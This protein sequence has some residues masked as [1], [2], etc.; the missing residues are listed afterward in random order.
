M[1]LHADGKTRGRKAGALLISLAVLLAAMAFVFSLS[2]GSREKHLL[3]LHSYHQ[4][5]KWTDDIARGIEAA[6]REEGKIVQVRHE[7]MDTKRI[8]DEAYFKLLHATYKYKFANSR[9]DAIIATDND[10]LDFLLTYRDDLFPETPVV[11]CG[12]N[13][14][15]PSR[16]GGA[17][18]FTGVNEA[19]DI[20]ATL[21]LALKLHP[22]TRHIVVINDTTTT[23]RIMN[24]EIM[25]LVPLYRGRV[26]FASLE[27][28]EM[29]QI[30][31]AVQNL[32][33][34]SIVLFTIFS[35][36]KRGRVFEYDESISLVAG[37]C[38]VPIY[39]VWDFNLGY[40][41][42]GGMLT[43]GFYQ[44]ETAGRMA[45]RILHGEKVENIPVVMESPN[46]YMFDYTQLKKFGLEVSAFPAG[47]IIINK[48]LPLYPAP[49]VF[50]GTIAVFAALVV[51]I[52]ILMRNMGMRRRAEEELRNTV[53][54]YRIIADNTYGWEFWLGPDGKFIY[55]SPSCECITGHSAK[56]FLDDP[57]LLRRIVH[58]DDQPQFDQHWKEILQGMRLGEDQWRILLSNGAVR[59]IDH[60]CMPVF[61]D[62]GQFLGVRGSNSDITERK[63]AEEALLE[64]EER[65]RTLFEGANDAIVIVR[66]GSFV[67][68]NRKTLEL[69]RCSAEEFLGRTP[70]EVSPLLQPDRRES[71]EK[72]REKMASALA[73]VPQFF[74][75]QHLRCDGTLF[76][77]EVSLNRTEYQGKEELQA[78]IRDITERKEMERMKDE[79]IS[80]VSHEMRTPLTA[81]LGF[82]EFL[83]EAEVEPKQR[84]EYLRIIYNETERLSELI[85]NFLDLQ[86]IKARQIVYDF[87]PLAVRPILEEA[88]ALFAGASKKHRLT[89]RIVE[90]LPPVR[91]DETRLHQVLNNLLSNAVKYSPEGGE[92]IL[93]AERD[94]DAVTFRVKDEGIGIAPEAQGKIFDRFYRVDGTDRRATG[95]TGLGLALVKE[96]VL[97]HG[98][99][100]WVESDQGKGSTFFFSLPIVKE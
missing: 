81:M 75:W 79:V 25:K 11:F 13:Y 45:V 62:N 32:P 22:E 60:L 86:R 51:V 41:I 33:A 80:A 28:M 49:A 53:L 91:G 88:A 92:I 98:G 39:G 8:S 23:G 29:P 100:V 27:E 16:L 43:S 74:E 94:G 4:G 3:V 84:K 40:G 93:G 44:G 61:D 20:K 78:I 56:E 63:Q 36:D 87:K 46:R 59:W 72:A 71:G 30:L 58:P 90:E 96:I 83:L 57:G 38:K 47:S 37:M 76:D 9:F 5:Y 55:S 99:R 24:R 21:D 14:F 26:D 64:S 7:Y 19:A 6:L 31:S 97:A 66:D 34:D 17:K 77:A 73:G 67:N 95:G 52:L 85:G 54:K 50:W 48:P 42:M 89:V 10:A 12:V 65:Y 70:A 68:C 82:T 18:L 15:E 1:P 35:R 2:E 69:F